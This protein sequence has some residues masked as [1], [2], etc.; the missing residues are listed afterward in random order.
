V[1]GKAGNIMQN[2]NGS[3]GAVRWLPLVMLLALGALWGGNP[4]FSKALVT[5][6]LSPAAVVFWQTFIA[7]VLLYA[8][9][10]MRGIRIPLNRRAV[11]YYF[12]IGLMGIDVSYMTLVYVVRHVP[13]GYASVVILL[14]PVLT[15]AIAVLVRLETVNL[16]RAAGILL[17]F[18]GAGL[19]VFPQGSLP[20]P[21]LLP[22]A[23][24]A[25]I[26]PVGYAIANVY[27][28]WGRP[29]GVDNVALATATMFAAALG[30]G[31][32]ALIDGTFHPIW[33]EIGQ[34]ELILVA[35]AVATGVAFLLFY[36]IVTSSGAVYLG[37]VGYLV[38]L[39]G[40]G[41]GILFFDE[42]TTIWLWGAVLVVGFGVALVNLGKRKAV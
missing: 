30:A 27:S 17:G 21:E 29:E 13:A 9:C 40:V 42:S 22:I 14:S 20:S 4:T 31:V 25:F 16:M 5:D 2:G 23:L 8:V 33:V 10:L 28:E 41:W 11:I 19:L 1:P 6:G 18:T 12:V 15:Y 26:T 38:T 24:L 36:K 37:Q 35:Y 34:R 7:G 3:S 39:F 32:V